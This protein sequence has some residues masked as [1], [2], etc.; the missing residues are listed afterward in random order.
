MTYWKI[1]PHFFYF[2]GPIFLS[3]GY[4]YKTFK[5]VVGLCKLPTKSVV[6]LSGAVQ[7]WCM[8]A[9][10]VKQLY[11]V[12]MDTKAKKSLLPWSM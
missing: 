3:R 11:S 5:K 1:G 9:F 7:M 8:T 10:K 2:C 12:G 6:I 4:F